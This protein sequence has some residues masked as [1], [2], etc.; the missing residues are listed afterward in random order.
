MTPENII[1]GEFERL[2]ALCERDTHA[3]R[4]L[5]KLEAIALRQ[6][7]EHRA[8]GARFTGGRAGYQRSVKLAARYFVV[9]CVTSTLR[10]EGNDVESALRALAGLRDDYVQGALLAAYLR[11]RGIPYKLS[12]ASAD[13]F[14]AID[15]ARDFAR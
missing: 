4:M 3:E 2:N 1:N 6:E 8:F 7:R 14:E 11:E 9:K 13:A 12:T 15:Y 10:V 5:V